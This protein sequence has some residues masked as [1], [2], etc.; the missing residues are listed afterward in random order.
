MPIKIDTIDSLVDHL[1]KSISF[2]DIES[3]NWDNFR[4][5][6]KP[7]ARLI[8]VT[9]NGHDQMKVETYIIKLKEQIKKG[10]LKNFC[11][12]EI[13][14]VA[15]CFGRICQVF[16]TYEAKFNPSD[17][18]LL[19][20]GIN[21]I[22]AVYNDGWAIA[23]LMWYNETKENTIPELYLPRILNEN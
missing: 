3:L 12:Y 22:Q 15:Q 20:R 11:E 18:K 1:Y 7:E 23:N 9:D 6:F 10:L 19:A 5:L 4:R 14:R 16:S 2:D 21:S 13:H 17:I 8:H